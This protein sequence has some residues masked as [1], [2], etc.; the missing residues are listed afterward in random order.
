[1]EFGESIGELET[2][3]GKRERVSRETLLSKVRGVNL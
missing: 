1:M 3:G 2:D